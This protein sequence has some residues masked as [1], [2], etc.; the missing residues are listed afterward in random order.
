MALKVSWSKRASIRFSEIIQYLE[1]EFGR[2]VSNTIAQD[3]YHTIEILSIFPD[4]GSLENHD[5]NI[6]GLVISKQI[7]LFYQVRSDRIVLLN[8]YDNRQNPY[9]KNL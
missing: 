1:T 8:F 2:K 6:R 4:M 9:K 7:T 5:Y 3:I